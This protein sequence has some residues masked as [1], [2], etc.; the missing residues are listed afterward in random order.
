MKTIGNRGVAA[1]TAHR[2]QLFQH[3]AS[4]VTVGDVVAVY[5]CEDSEMYWLAEVIQ[6][7]SEYNTV[8]PVLKSKLRCPVSEEEFDAGEQ[9]MWVTYYDRLTPRVFRYC[10]FLGVFMVPVAMLRAGKVSLV[11]QVTRITRTQSQSKPKEDRRYELSEDEHT[12]VMN[13][14]I[15]DFKDIK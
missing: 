14:I 13:S 2:K 11:E 8:T 6:P 3:L 1:H 7:S 5:T 10:P 12:R 4:E 9:V 15:H